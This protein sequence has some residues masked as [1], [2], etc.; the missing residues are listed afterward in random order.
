MNRKFQKLFDLFPDGP[1][2]Q[3]I[4][5][6]GAKLAINEANDYGIDTINTDSLFRVTMP[7]G[8]SL[9]A[10]RKTRNC[11]VVSI[12]SPKTTI[13]N[14]QLVL[15]R[16][17]TTDIGSKYD[18]K[19]NALIDVGNLGKDMTAIRQLLAE[20]IYKYDG[21]PLSSIPEKKRAVMQL[22]EL[23]EE[24]DHLAV[25]K[26]LE[27]YFK[28]LNDN[29]KRTGSWR[30]DNTGLFDKDTGLSCGEDEISVLIGLGLMEY[31]QDFT[32]RM[33]QE[34]KRLAKNN[35]KKVWWYITGGKQSMAKL[36]A[37]LDKNSHFIVLNNPESIYMHIQQSESKFVEGVVDKFNCK[38]RH[39]DEPEY[40]E[41]LCGKKH[42]QI[43]A[44]LKGCNSCK[45]V[46]QNQERAKVETATDGI[47]EN[48]KQY[49]L[50]PGNG[51]LRSKGTA[52]ANPPNPSHLKKQEEQEWQSRNGEV[53]TIQG[54]TE[55]IDPMDFQALADDNRRVANALLAKAAWF[56]ETADK[57]EALL[58]PSTA[59]REAEEALRL[60]KE[61]EESDRAKQV[62][63]LQRM[64]VDGP[65]T[66]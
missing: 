24:C 52:P 17:I 31:Y 19:T 33:F 40:G 59:I 56:E 4:A 38:V 36:T 63:A 5:E 34:E 16:T 22:I 20:E 12:E 29:F 32:R 18:P 55:G 54:P 66:A 50:S 47:S 11:W 35:G 10:R 62:A 51:R 13:N 49:Q 2:S 37:T 61:S 46:Q 64:L 43:N 60:A 45:R 25:N 53:I 7:S 9:E 28:E 14:A 58:R 21:M 3:A 6:I 39:C 27:A 65:P 57:Y 41:T 44:H 48:Q 15:Q 1:P 8:S 23:I 26:T 42:A 30:A